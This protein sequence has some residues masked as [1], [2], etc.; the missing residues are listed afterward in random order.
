ME[1]TYVLEYYESMALKHMKCLCGSHYRI[2]AAVTKGRQ[3]GYRCNR[4]V[5]LGSTLHLL[6]TGI[7]CKTLKI[8][9]GPF[10]S[11][12]YFLCG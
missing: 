5:M 8:R 7:N 11:L 1:G 6:R 9:S 4:G 12:V 10:R 2:P 3:T